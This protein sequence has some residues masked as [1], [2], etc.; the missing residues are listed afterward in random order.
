MC[1]LTREKLE[2]CKKKIKNNLDFI[3]LYNESSMV[4]GTSALYSPGV[5]VIK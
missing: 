5:K 3:I 4:S 2:K 1:H